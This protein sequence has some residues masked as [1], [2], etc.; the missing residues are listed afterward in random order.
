[1]EQY[2][3]E[4]GQNDIIFTLIIYLAYGITLGI[5]IHQLQNRQNTLIG[6]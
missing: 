4:T 3:P 1:M 5:V 2:Y 6:K